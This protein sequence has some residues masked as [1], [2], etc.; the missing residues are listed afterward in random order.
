MRQARRLIAILTVCATWCMVSTTTA[1]AAML[2][3][4]VP[5]GSVVV[6]SNGAA[7]GA[8][9]WDSA[10]PA[11]LGVLLVLAV[12][13]LVFALRHSWRPEHSRRSE[14]GVRA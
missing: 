10:A 8:P 12:T 3:D 7:V 11:V 13:G 2:H 14:T 5:A 6:P 4:P 9:F 1:F